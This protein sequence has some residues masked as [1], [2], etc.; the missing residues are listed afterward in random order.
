MDSGNGYRGIDIRMVFEKWVE[1]KIGMGF[2]R[3]E[4]AS[5]LLSVLEKT[6]LS[7]QFG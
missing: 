6:G 5:S 7:I 2:G 1:F 4:M 3:L